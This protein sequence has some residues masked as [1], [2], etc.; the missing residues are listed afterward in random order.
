MCVSL[1]RWRRLPGMGLLREL[2]FVSPLK[3]LPSPVPPL[4]LRK[5]ISPS[6]DWSGQG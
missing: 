1:S 3:A 6:V 4:I 2:Q 5:H